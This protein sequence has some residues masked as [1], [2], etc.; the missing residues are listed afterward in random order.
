MSKKSVSAL[1]EVSSASKRSILKTV[2]EGSEEATKKRTSE[3][4]DSTIIEFPKNQ[5]DNVT[6]Q[7]KYLDLSNI[8]NTKINVKNF[9][10][11]LVVLRLSGTKLPPLKEFPQLNSLRTLYLDHCGI[12]TLEG[13]PLFT[14]LRY[15]YLNDNQ[16]ENYLGM[17]FYPELTAIDLSNNP[18][19]F[20][21]ETA[22]QATGALGLSS[23]NGIAITL[24]NVREAFQSPI[25]GIALRHGLDPEDANEMEALKYLSKDIYDMYQELDENSKVPCLTLEKDE[26]NET[27]YTVFPIQ[28]TNKADPNSITA[29]DI[30]WYMNSCPFLNPKNEEWEIISTEQT[31]RIPVINMMAQHI[32]R[33]TF[34][35]YGYDNTYSMYLPQ[36]LGYDKKKRQLVLPFPVNPK[37]CGEPREGSLISVLPMPV[38]SRS[39]WYIENDCILENSETLLLDYEQVGKRITC[40]IQPYCAEL[41]EA[42]FNELTTETEEV[43]QLQ[44]TITGIAFPQTIIEGEQIKFARQMMPDREGDSEITIERAKTASGQWEQCTT[45]NP[46]SLVYTPTGEDVGCFLRMIYLPVLNNGTTLEEPLIFYAKERVVPAIPSFTNERVVGDFLV[47]RKVIAIADYQGGEKGECAYQWYSSKKPVTKKSELAKA[48]KIKANNSPMI[49]LG[50]GELNRYIVCV[51]TPIRDDDV[52]GQE[53]IACSEEPVAEDEDPPA[54][55]ELPKEVVAFKPINID[56]NARW[57]V[58]STEDEDSFESAG[59]GSTFTPNETHIGKFLRIE[60][61]SGTYILGQVLPAAQVIVPFDLVYNVPESQIEDGVVTKV[62]DGQTAE[63]PEDIDTENCEITWVRMQNG[64]IIVVDVETRVYTFTQ[65]DVNYSIKAGLVPIVD[66]VPQDIVFSHASPKVSKM[67]RGKP[68]ISGKKSHNQ[69]L[70]LETEISPIYEI[71]WFRSKDKSNWEPVMTYTFS[72]ID[73]NTER[74]L[75][76]CV[77]NGTVIA[78]DLDITNCIYKTGDRDVNNYIKVEFDAGVFSK[79]T[80]KKSEDSFTVVTKDF[81]DPASFEIYLDDMPENF[82]EGSTIHLQT[83]GVTKDMTRPTVVWQRF[84]VNKANEDQWQIISEGMKYKVTSED[85]G[86]RLRAVAVVGQKPKVGD[87]VSDAASESISDKLIVE[88][89]EI[90]A[91]PPSLSDV[92]ITQDSSGK[93]L[94]TAVYHG[95]EAGMPKALFASTGADGL[96][97]EEKNI[98]ENLIDVSDNKI[99][100]RVTPWAS[101]FK[102]SGQP[103]VDAVIIPTREDG[104]QGTPVWTSSAAVIQKVPMIQKIAVLNKDKAFKIGATINAEIKF[105]DAEASSIVKNYEWTF[106]KQATDED[107]DAFN[108]KF[109]KAS[110]KSDKKSTKSRKSLLDNETK[111]QESDEKEITETDSRGIKYKL[112]YNEDTN[113]IKK[114]YERSEMNE[115]VLTEF[116]SKSS[117]TLKVWAINK[118]GFE[119]ESS[120]RVK[121]PQLAEKDLE[122]KITIVIPPKDRSV[123]VKG[124]KVFETDQAQ[125]YTD[126]IIHAEFTDVEEEDD[127]TWVVADANKE[128]EQEIQTSQEFRANAMYVGK[129]VFARLNDLESEPIGPVVA[130]INLDTVARS[131]RKSGTL[132]FKGTAPVGNGQWDVSFTSQGIVMTGRNKVTKKTAWESVNILIQENERLEIETGPGS[133]FV[134]VPSLSKE[135]N[136]EETCDL[137]YLIYAKYKAPKEEDYQSPTKRGVD[138]SVSPRASRKGSES[139]SVSPRMKK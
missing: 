137:I 123:K 95:G 47:G 97:V 28:V 20:T 108:E 124:K 69:D 38:P 14:K 57:Y 87:A 25:I 12:K 89:P 73:R 72:N 107:V 71:R 64:K 112:I 17:S 24:A 100:V 5:N 37:V 81:I 63:I 85:I 39:S 29:H 103:K 131:Y 135:Y 44:P 41:P 82:T 16:L 106:T 116:E 118:L 48:S 10:N 58:S 1:S 125:L 132:K 40:V 70:S 130:C 80:V 128:N 35:V 18:G 96:T 83:R 59:T 76:R 84:S 7:T 67:P 78:E 79:S 122:P 22:L 52:A 94:L 121:I 126:D 43:V 46:S 36:V 120:K 136:T 88:I 133:K 104:V 139:G 27:I 109:D 99:T 86:Q 11:N 23:F 68:K 119:G 102:G 19:K 62:Y 56:V 127:P 4:V 60:S 53:V 42:R 34:K 8:V 6:M 129:Y 101:L 105:D 91:A 45:L 26:D 134:M 110:V 93:I 115:F 74:E 77:V 15:F 51:M 21:A 13:M 113:D 65:E 49:E 111:E 55:L 33:V 30:R 114:V 90:V 66:K 32:I 75:Y 61:E 9:P 92:N 54:E 2:G 31:N 138:T 50:E 117:L 3:L 98:E